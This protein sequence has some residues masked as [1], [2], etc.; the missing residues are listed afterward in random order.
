MPRRKQQAPR[1]SAGNARGPRRGERGPGGA[2]AGGRGS[3]PRCGAG[4]AGRGPAGRGGTPSGGCGRPELGREAGPARPPSPRGCRLRPGAPTWAGA[5]SGETS[6]R[7]PAL[8][9]ARTGR[10]ARGGRGRGTAGASCY[11][12]RGRALGEEVAPPWPERAGKVLQR[13]ETE[14]DT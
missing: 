9:E 6:R 2:G 10:E 8:G 12:G 13:R 7:F 1:R 11:L 3:R 5:W 4:V 14:P